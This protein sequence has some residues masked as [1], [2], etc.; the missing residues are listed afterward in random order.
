MGGLG[1]GISFFSLVILSR[2][3]VVQSHAYLADPPSRNLVRATAGFEDCPHCLNSNGPSNVATRG[4]NVWPT[5]LAP[6]GH[7]LCGDPVQGHANPPTL[8][9]EEYLVPTDAQKTYTAGSVVEFRVVVSTHHTGHYE[10]RLCNTV[11]DGATL[12]SSKEAASLPNRNRHEVVFSIIYNLYIQ[13]DPNSG[14]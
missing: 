6:E 11:L 8:A 13:M 7:G 12:Q 3:Q 10:Y 1:G 2:L 9:D 14:A 5:H 4:N